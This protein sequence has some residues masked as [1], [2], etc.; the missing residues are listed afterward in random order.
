[1]LFNNS[2]KSDLSKQRIKA[3][4]GQTKGGWLQEARKA[5][6]RVVLSATGP[7]IRLLL[8]YSLLC[9]REG[10]LRVGALGALR[11]ARGRLSFCPLAGQRQ[12]MQIRGHALHGVGAGIDQVR[13]EA[14]YLGKK[15]WGL[16]ASLAGG[17]RLGL[18]EDA[19]ARQAGILAEHGAGRAIG[20]AQQGG[21]RDV[22][23]GSGHLDTGNAARGIL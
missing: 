6:A 22:A 11:G 2:A 1:M 17:I 21:L 3:H 7:L 4:E 15:Q 14:I 8:L 13:R 9:D 12:E 23:G 18:D 5:K 10:R 16:A 20:I 19:N